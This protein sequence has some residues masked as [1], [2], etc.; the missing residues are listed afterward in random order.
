MLLT[1]NNYIFDAVFT[2]IIDE[3]R[4]SIYVFFGI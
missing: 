1:R 4:I 3:S 2:K